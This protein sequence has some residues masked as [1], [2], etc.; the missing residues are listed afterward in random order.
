MDIRSTK[1]R[2]L[3]TIALLGASL[4]SGAAIACIC[5]TGTIIV[6]KFYDANANGIHDAGEVRLSNWPMT[7]GSTTLGTLGTLLTDAFGYATFSGT[8]VGG[9]YTMTEGTPIE[10]NW[11]Q[12]SPKVNGVPVNPITGIHVTAGYTTQLSFGNYCTKPSGGRTP[13][14][15]SNKNGEAT[16]LDGSPASLLPELNLL[17]SLNL[18]GANGNAFDPVDY[19]SF[20]AWLLA[21][22]ATNMAYKLSS[23]LAAMRL[24]VEAGFVNGNALYAPYGGDQRAHQ[25]REYVPRLVPLHAGRPS[26]AREP[27]TTEE[28]PRRAQQ[29][30]RR[31]QP[32]AL[33]ADVPGVLIHCACVCV[34]HRGPLSGGA[35]FCC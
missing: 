13:G 25:C 14:F 24:N 29:R 28:L 10:G 32:G 5:S 34:T 7:L 4:V 2:R 3:L 16:M 15:W 19:P 8:P 1:P 22:D 12:S 20:R 17:G 33:Q 18:V 27:G 11:V 30:R 26:A 31:G 35:R 6:K 9:N 21:S 23:H